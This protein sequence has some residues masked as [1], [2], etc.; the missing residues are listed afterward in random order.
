MSRV[1]VAEDEAALAFGLKLDLEAEGY[2][3]ET[4]GDGET[5]LQ[6]A[7]T[8][9]FDLILLDLMLPKKDGLE[10]LRSLRRAGVR[11][12]VIILTA[13][14]QE[15]EKILGLETGADDYITKPF[16]PRELRARVRA[17]L[18]RT[19]PTSASEPDMYA[20]ADVE[21]D[22][23]RHEVRRAGTPIDLTPIEFNLLATFCR[24][25]GRALTREQLLDLAWGRGIAVTERVV[26]SH[27]VR[28]RKAIEP[29]PSNPRFIVSV[30][31]VGYRFEG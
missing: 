6:R 24:N 29:D 12:Q 13:R 14:A 23:T 27:V 25:R 18:R 21:V 16:S 15:A 28:V 26:D 4:A 2:R 5:A 20:F 19:T 11:T 8:G 17:A 7:S 3:V 31:T 22:F 10:V 9:D 1:L 30:R